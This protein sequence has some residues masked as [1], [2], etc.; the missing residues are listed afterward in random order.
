MSVSTIEVLPTTAALMHAAAR[1]FVVSAATVARTSG[2]FVVALSGGSTPK[3]L[4]ALLATKAYATQVD[5]P[6]VQLFWGDERCVPP[7]DPDSNYRMVSETLLDRV[8]LP[9]QNVHR[10]R[11]EDDPDAAA[12]G[13]EQELRQTFSTPEGAARHA[14]GACF[15]LILLG[16]GGNG[17]TASLFPGMAALH[18][19]RRWVMAQRIPGVSTWRIT[20]TPVVINAATSVIFVV[21]GGEK[22]AMLRRVIEGPY[23]PDALPAQVIAP[24]QGRLGWLVDA[25]AASLLQKR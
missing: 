3:R 12:V 11:G 2:R 6:L 19:P 21:A 16:M 4:Y 13:Y 17:H 22:A 23:R 25:E 8:P 18:E 9:A 20:L 1:Q 14:P 7:D 10:I 15:D 24:R 5:W